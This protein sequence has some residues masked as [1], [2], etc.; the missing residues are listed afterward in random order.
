MAIS[1]NEILNRLIGDLNEAHDQLLPD[2]R[3]RDFARAQEARETIQ[4][5]LKKARNLQRCLP[6]KQFDPN[7]LED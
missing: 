7:D 1:P 3:Q 2:G 4:Q 5:A 6:L